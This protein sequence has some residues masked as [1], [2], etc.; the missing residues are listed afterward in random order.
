MALLI[1]VLI[2]GRIVWWGTA[3]LGY[4]LAGSAILLGSSLLI[5]HN[6]ANPILQ[7]RWLSG[8]D[9]VR[10]AL[11]GA[12]VRLLLSEQSVGGAGLLGA[13]GMGSFELVTFYAIVTVASLAG[14]A[15]SI[16]RLDPMD[17]ARPTL[18]ALLLIA[19]ASFVDYGASLQTRPEQ[20]YVTQA[21]IG[22]AALY[23]MGPTMMEGLL[24]ALANGPRH[25]ISFSAIF[26]ISQ[27]LGGLIGAVA[28]ASCVIIPNRG[29]LRPSKRWPP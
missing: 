23:F 29:T 1:A 21:M 3:W 9:I 13:L 8:A 18:T 27:A 26:G 10:F 7:T 25:I 14:L 2:Q 19:I 4:T 17:I 6:R 16:V 11:V 28:G 24:R 15:L 22:F 20:L 5:E 12:S